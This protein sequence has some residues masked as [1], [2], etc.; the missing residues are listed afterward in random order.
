[1]LPMLAIPGL[2]GC[3]ATSTRSGGVELSQRSSGSMD[4]TVDDTL[5]LPGRPRVSRH[6]RGTPRATSSCTSPTTA[7]VVG[8]TICTWHPITGKRDAQLRLII[9]NSQALAIAS[10]LE[11]SMTDLVLVG[12]GELWSSDRPRR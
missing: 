12:H 2:G 9:A 7:S 11:H 3:S 4:L 6:C 10:A 1:M 8:D 5:D